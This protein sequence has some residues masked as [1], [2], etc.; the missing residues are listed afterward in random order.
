MW[1][2][3]IFDCIEDRRIAIETACCPCYRFGKNMRR[4]NLGPCFLQG[5]VYFV[6]VLAILF[7]FIAFVVTRQFCYLYIGVASAVT[8]ALYSGYFRARIKKRFN[9]EGSDHSLSH[10]VYHL[11][12]PCCALCQESRT[13]EMNNVQGGVWHGRGDAICVGS[14]GEGSKEFSALQKPS[15]MQTIAPEYNVMD[16]SSNGS[17]HSWTL[18]ADHSEPLVSA[19]S[20][21]P[22]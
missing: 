22:S 20:G 8:C 14:Y 13:L 15:L 21:Q 18:D 1:E 12:C 19:Q 11:I 9:I 2:G 17:N 10:C 7:N 5:S 4:A 3:A 6:L 16:R